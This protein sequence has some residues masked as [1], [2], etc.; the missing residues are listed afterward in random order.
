MKRKIFSILFA[1]LLVLSFSL[2]LA[3]P[4]GANLV[5]TYYVSTTGDN[6]NNGLSWGTAWQ[7]IQYANSQAVYGD[8]INVAAGTYYEHI[9]LKDGVEV[10]GA[11]ASVTTINGG[12]SGTVVTA[13]GVD[14]E[15]KLDGFTITN[16]SATN[17][18]GMYNY[19][20]SSPVVTNCTFSGNS[21]AYG[22]GMLNDINSPPTVTNCIFSDNSASMSGGGM[23]N[24]R[25]LTTVT[26]CT[27]SGNSATY[28]GGMYSYDST[29]VVTNCILWDG[30]G[31]IYNNTST[32]V[33][34]YCDIQGGYTGTG[35][36]DADPLFVGAGDYH[37]QPG[38]PCI[39][40]GNN[41]A[42][43]LPSTDFEGDPRILN[44]VVDMGVDEYV[45]HEV[46][47]DD[48]WQIGVPPYDEDTDGDTDFATIK[49]AIA[50]V[51]SGGTVHVHPGTYNEKGIVIDKSLTVQSV[52]GDWH[53]TIVDPIAG[54][55]FEFATN[56]SGDATISGF[57]I[58]VGTLGIYID[59]LADTGT[60]NITDCLIYDNGT[61]IFASGTLDG[62]IFI[63]DCI[64]SDNGA[65]ATGIHLYDI[66]GTVEITDSVIGAYWDAATSTSYSGNAGNGIEIVRISESGNVLLDNNKIVNN[67]GNGIEDD[68]LLSGVYGRLTIT[69]NIIG[70]YDYA[71]TSGDGYFT[72]NGNHGISIAYVG[73]DGVVTIDGNKIAQN[74][75]D[76]IELGVG[77][78]VEG[79]VTI[80]NNYIGAWTLRDGRKS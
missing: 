74:G 22:G 41:A 64:I 63:D 29:P 35:N 56:F 42:P 5:D 78:P 50:A 17:G 18:G 70:A 80:N 71:L 34:T 60:I 11:G 47:V 39:D 33:V 46:W 40:V 57:T 21:A 66:L 36:I 37:L 27:F 30:G 19:N 65:P 62:D 31:E 26:N 43:S 4:V 54:P 53:D 52:S 10:L 51:A 44:G 45:P 8:T 25:S 20:S 68:T 23:Y 6:G 55:V 2:V 38:S 76:G 14:S 48:D 61:G 58:A 13:N 32:P 77:L 73:P 3:L 7:D 9:T 59:G 67:T 1:L 72:G 28:G 24:Q 12:G 49:A 79:D 16:G 15:T 75:V 69:N